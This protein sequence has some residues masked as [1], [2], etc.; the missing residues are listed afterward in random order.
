MTQPHKSKK[1]AALAVIAMFG[2]AALTTT[3]AQ[4]QDF[5]MSVDV[6]LRGLPDDAN[7][8]VACGVTDAEGQIIGAGG[9]LVAADGKEFEGTVQVS[10]DVN[11]NQDAALAQDYKCVLTIAGEG[12]MS[13]EAC[14]ANGLA[15]PS[16]HVLRCG[17]EGTSV[18][19]VLEG[20]LKDEAAQE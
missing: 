3:L 20:S 19:S 18:V 16:D 1:I 17:A 9:Q 5:I 11:E 2:A 4:A 7:P 6:V 13:W 15:P 14:T 8:G 12:P 10:F